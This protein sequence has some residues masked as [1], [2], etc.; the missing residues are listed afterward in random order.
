MLV[1]LIDYYSNFDE[2]WLV[3]ISGTVILALDI[4]ILLEGF[5]ALRNAKPNEAVS[6]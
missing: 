4:W 5:T 1:N 2:L 6:N 3:S